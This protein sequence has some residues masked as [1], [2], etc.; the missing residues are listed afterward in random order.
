MPSKAAVDFNRAR[1]RARLLVATAS[2]HPGKHS[3]PTAHKAVCLHAALA[4]LVAGWEAY[5][6]RV[7]REAQ[8]EIAD[9]TQIRLSVVLALLTEITENEI[10]RF[11]TPN[12]SNSRTLL[13]AHTGYDPINDWQWAVGGLNGVQ[14]RARLDE[15]LQIRHS[16]AHGFPVPTNINW[17]KNRN[18]AGVLNTSVLKSVEKFLAHIVL[19]T[20]E[21]LKSH[22]SSKFGVVLSW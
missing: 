20:D 1:F 3:N 13:I 21:G 14:A 17:V 9:N 16:F 18:Q 5:L 22:L 12:A 7:V 4:M 15:I 19:V 8:R 10:K 11:N 6:E 2:A